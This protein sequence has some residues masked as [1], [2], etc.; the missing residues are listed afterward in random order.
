[1]SIKDFLALA[2]I[3]ELS[4]KKLSDIER[5]FQPLSDCFRS[6]PSEL[7]QLGLSETIIEQI[8]HPLWNK[9]DQ[10][11]QW[12]EQ[13]NHR[14][15]TW[16][17]D[18]YPKRLK[19]T[20]APAPILFVIGNSA[21]LNHPKP[22]AMVGSRH[23][24]IS[25]KDI[26]YDFASALANKG[27]C[28]VSGLALGI[29]SQSHLGAL[30]GQG[31]TIA[32]LGSG[33]NVVYPKRN[34]ALFDKISYKGAI[35]SE[36][37]L[38]SAPMRHHFPQRNRIISGLSA[39]VLVVE[40]AKKSG[41]LITAMTALEQGREVFAIPS[42]IH[43]PLAKGCHALIQQGGKLVETIDD[44][45]VEL[46]FES[47]PSKVKTTKKLSPTLDNDLQNLVQFVGYETTAIDAIAENAGLSMVET[48]H[49]LAQLEL[50]GIIAAV[51][52]GY[53]RV[54]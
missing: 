52:G 29:D 53:L 38:D 19:E 45:L 44:I 39:G 50:E 46:P 8:K 48:T 20:H 5:Y 28:I 15:I 12:A 22:F 10:A 40:A 43:N 37:P 27:L 9:V 25:G 16:H 47:P 49:R 33:I 3:K 24:S 42:S 26:A 13:P 21:L 31:E 41:S 32:V 17:C 51:P 35:I 4:P 1:M 6:K 23:P 30:E 54:Q 7:R 2:H 36:F 11:L 34:Q 14:L 18:D